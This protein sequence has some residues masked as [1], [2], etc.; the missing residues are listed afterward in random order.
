[1]NYSLLPLGL[2]LASC[3]TV[4]A[5]PAPQGWQAVA[6]KADERRLRE[7]R[8]AF[9]RAI[10]QA[11]K[12]GH[13][14]DIVR[15]GR[16]LVPDAAI[17]P[18]PIPNGEY[19]CRVIKV[20]A[21]SEGMLDF[22]AY[23]AFQCRIEQAGALQRFTKLTGSQRQAGLVYPANALRQIFLGTLVL[24]DETRA[25]DYGQ[26]PDRDLAGWVEQVEPGRWR[27]ILPYPRYESTIDVVELI[28]AA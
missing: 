28:P 13:G 22:I 4:Q 11:T 19:R 27:L 7:W 9:T 1:M 10:D 3:T 17:G 23:P 8:T 14:P 24:G 20:G 6:T 25:M 12:A 16:L 18:V 5:P 2:L 21:R 26:D 15:E